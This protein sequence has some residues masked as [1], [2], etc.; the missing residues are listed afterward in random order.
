MRLKINICGNKVAEESE[1]KL[2]KQ[3]LLHHR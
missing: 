3:L 2:G 1:E